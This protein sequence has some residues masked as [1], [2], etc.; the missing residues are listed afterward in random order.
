M[1]RE[2]RQDCRW[3]HR[4][5]GFV[6][7]AVATRQNRA[8]ERRQLWPILSADETRNHV[9]PLLERRTSEQIAQRSSLL[10]SIAQVQYPLD[11][12][13]TPG[14]S[15]KTLGKYR[16]VR[17]GIFRRAEN[18]PHAGISRGVAVSGNS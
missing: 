3:Q 12:T 17:E 16:Y 15:L 8:R 9:T 6:C 10:R 13:D 11:V 1:R 7:R 5:Q 2:A 18:P 4:K 14:D